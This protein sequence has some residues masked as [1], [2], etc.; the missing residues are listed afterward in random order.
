MNNINAWLSAISSPLF[1]Q[2]ENNILVCPD[3]PVLSGEL[4]WPVQYPDLFRIPLLI[5][6]DQVYS[7]TLLSCKHEWSVQLTIHSIVRNGAP[8]PT[9][10]CNKLP[11]WIK[12]RQGQIPNF[13]DTYNQSTEYMIF[14]CTTI[15]LLLQIYQGIWIAICIYFTSAALLYS[16]NTQNLTN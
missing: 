1:L 16:F 2:D 10:K 4:L 15:T 7:Y 8:T 12:M 11:W 5:C 14:Q 9:P 3:W 13:A 6:C